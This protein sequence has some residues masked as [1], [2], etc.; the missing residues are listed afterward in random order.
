MKYIGPADIKLRTEQ[1][2]FLQSLNGKIE[3]DAEYLG[4]WDLFENEGSL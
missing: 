4:A 2:C 3:D 1:L